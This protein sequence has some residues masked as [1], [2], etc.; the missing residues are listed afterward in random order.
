MDLSEMPRRRR[1]VNFFGTGRE[2]PDET[3]RRLVET[4]AP[5]WAHRA[6]RAQKF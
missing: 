4:A 5:A 6:Q 2:L 1:A 3:P